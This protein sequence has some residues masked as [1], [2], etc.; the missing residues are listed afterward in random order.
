MICT[1]IPKGNVKQ[2]IYSCKFRNTNRLDNNG[3]KWT[4]TPK[5]GPWFYLTDRKTGTV[6][7]V[8]VFKF[9][10]AKTERCT[11]IERAWPVQYVRLTYKNFTIPDH[12]YM[13]SINSISLTLSS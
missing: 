6:L 1:N 4:L 11:I 10:K 5:E 12:F 2:P 7:L 3:R 13:E 9:P 8:A